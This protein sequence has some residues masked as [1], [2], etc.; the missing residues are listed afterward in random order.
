MI[1][2]NDLPSALVIKRIA[3]CTADAERIGYHLTDTPASF[4]HR[5]IDVIKRSVLAESLA[6][7]TLQLQIPHT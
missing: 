3:R 7:R 6:A 4:Q 2:R 5:W 1:Y